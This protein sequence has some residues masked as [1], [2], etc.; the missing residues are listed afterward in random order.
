M[1]RFAGV[2]LIE[3]VLQNGRGL[4]T[5]VLSSHFGTPSILNLNE[6][7]KFSGA[8]WQG[9]IFL[10]PSQVQLLF[11]DVSEQATGR[12]CCPCDVCAIEEETMMATMTS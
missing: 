5:V 3:L 12:L 6:K 8:L 9:D 7:S 11:G 2:M 10:T 4:V 1:Q